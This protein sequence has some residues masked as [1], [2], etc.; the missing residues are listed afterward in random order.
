MNDT[1]PQTEPIAGFLTHLEPIKERVRGALD[2]ASETTRA[3]PRIDPAIARKMRSQIGRLLTAAQVRD[4][5][6]QR[7]SH[8]EAALE[9]SM[10][11]S[12]AERGAVETVIAR[13][14]VEI[15]EVLGKT[16]TEL[17]AAF[18]AISDLAA[19]TDLAVDPSSLEEVSTL[20]ANGLGAAKDLASAGEVLGAEAAGHFGMIDSS[21]APQEIQEAN[22]DWMFELYTMDEERNVHR[23]A[24]AQAGAA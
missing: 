3:L 6:D 13:Q 15:S 23:L 22:L 5:F 18:R 19:S 14:L 4:N 16:S 9:R 1:S 12:P 21:L 2:W 20:A 10:T 7:I 11:L 24:I 17:A 8:V